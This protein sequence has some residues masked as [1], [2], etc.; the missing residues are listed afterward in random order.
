MRRIAEK[1][2]GVVEVS[3]LGVLLLFLKGV[4]EKEWFCCG[5]LMVS[6]W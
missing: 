1:N 3:F 6:L 5:E 4:L 2:P